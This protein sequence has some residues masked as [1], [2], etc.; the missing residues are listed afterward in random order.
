MNLHN[1]YTYYNWINHVAKRA[2]NLNTINFKDITLLAITK[3]GMD[4]T[5]TKATE[6]WLQHY[7]FKRDTDL[8]LG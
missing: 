7:N 5:V 3:G 6:M 2:L 8:T 4:H 1:T